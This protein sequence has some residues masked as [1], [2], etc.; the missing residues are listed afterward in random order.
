MSTRAYFIKEIKMEESPSFTFNFSGGFY[1][2]IEEKLEDKGDI[3]GI[4][5]DD[6]ESGF[7]SFKKEHPNESEEIEFLE[8]QLKEVKETGQDYLEFYCY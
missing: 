1:K 5:V 3:V 4:H 6:Y 7:N 8:K 2:F